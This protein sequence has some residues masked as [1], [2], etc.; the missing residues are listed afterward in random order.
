MNVNTPSAKG[1]IMY[2]A[3][4]VTIYDIPYNRYIG[5][6]YNKAMDIARAYYKKYGFSKI[7]IEQWENGICVRRYRFILATKEG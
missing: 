5:S 7:V 1:K 3:V 6:D 4:V 2:Y